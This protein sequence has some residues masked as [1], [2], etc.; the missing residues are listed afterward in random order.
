RSG[1]DRQ[2]EPG[3]GGRHLERVAVRLERG[4]DRRERL[5]C[6]G[7]QGLVGG[8]RSSLYS[9]D[10]V[11]TVGLRVLSPI[12]VEAAP[13]PIQPATQLGAAEL[14]LVVVPHPF[15]TMARGDVEQLAATVADRVR[16]ALVR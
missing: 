13:E 15:A 14:R 6:A 16:E 1:D 9:A 10:M 11:E 4:L 5:A 12:G 2:C 3:V 8:H 7:E